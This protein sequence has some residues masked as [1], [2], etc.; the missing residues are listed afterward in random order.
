MLIAQV[1]STMGEPFS[2]NRKCTGGKMEPSFMERAYRVDRLAIGS[3]RRSCGSLRMRVVKSGDAS[4]WLPL[5]TATRAA[6]IILK[7]AVTLAVE[8]KAVCTMTCVPT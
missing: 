1:V 4:A 5:G 6:S 8:G 7:V 3:I 2:F